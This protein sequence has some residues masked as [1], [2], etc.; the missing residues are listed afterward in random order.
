MTSPAPGSTLPGSSATFSWSAATGGLEYFL[1]VGTSA[2]ANNLYGRSMG[3]N[4][5]VTLSGIPTNGS[6]LYVRLW[7]RTAAGWQYN[8]YTYRAAF[9]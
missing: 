2:G 4:R 1:Y 9:Q 8:D 5:S 7:T 6:T 3:T